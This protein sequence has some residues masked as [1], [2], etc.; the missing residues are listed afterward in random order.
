MFFYPQMRPSH[1]NLYGVIKFRKGPAVKPEY[2]CNNPDPRDSSDS[3]RNI[4]VDMHSLANIVNKITY[5]KLQ[6][7]PPTHSLTHSHYSPTHS[8]PSILLKSPYKT[9]S[10]TYWDPKGMVKKRPG[11]Y[12]YHGGNTHLSTQ[13]K[14]RYIPKYD[15][16]STLSQTDGTDTLNDYKKSCEWNTYQKRMWYQDCLD[17]TKEEYE[18][19]PGIHAEWRKEGEFEK[20]YRQY[21]S[22]FVYD[23]RVNVTS[24]DANGVESREQLRTSDHTEIQKLRRD[25][26]E[27]DRYDIKSKKTVDFNDLE[28]PPKPSLSRDNSNTSELDIKYFNK[29]NSMRRSGSSGGPRRHPAINPSLCSEHPRETFRKKE[30]FPLFWS[31]TQKED[32]RQH[33]SSSNL[34]DTSTGRT[35]NEF[36]ASKSE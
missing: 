13:Y 19:F 28:S 8:H 23:F 25:M 31:E 24:T 17:H 9:M 26:N 35:A 12:T 22:K 29:D 21:N 20:S 6:S 32:F 14:E 30:Q 10:H 11:G 27:K 16:S 34:L 3:P 1:Y 4:L 5:N 7:S 18:N 33:R 36:S 15:P 2:R